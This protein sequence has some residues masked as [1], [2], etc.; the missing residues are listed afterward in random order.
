MTEKES[1]NPDSI[2]GIAVSVSLLFLFNAIQ[3]IKNIVQKR[4][5]DISGFHNRSVLAD[6][7][8]A[9]FETMKKFSK[10]KTK[11]AKHSQVNSLAFWEIL[12]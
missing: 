12:H 3:E 4:R 1:F 7:F 6:R 5:S 11:E 10:V 8:P 9:I 2:N